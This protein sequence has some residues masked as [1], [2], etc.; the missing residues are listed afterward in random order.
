MM[1][2]RLPSHCYRPIAT[3]PAMLHTLPLSESHPPGGLSETSVTIAKLIA[4]QFP[5]IRSSYERES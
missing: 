5:G 1:S 3:M 4:T 2:L